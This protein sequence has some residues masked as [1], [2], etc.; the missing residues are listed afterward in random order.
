MNSY[1]S[2][3]EIPATDI[4]RAVNFYEKVLGIKIEKLD[5][6]DMKMGLLPYENQMNT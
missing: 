5:F 2:I 1:I 4:G 3:F 6:P